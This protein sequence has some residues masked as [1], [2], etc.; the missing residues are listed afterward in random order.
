MARGGLDVLLRVYLVTVWI[1]VHNVNQEGFDL[2][3]YLHHWPNADVIVY[4][5]ETHLIGINKQFLYPASQSQGPNSPCP[6][7]AG[8]T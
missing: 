8:A 6:C 1:R 7:V 3:D 4:N 5:L 2:I